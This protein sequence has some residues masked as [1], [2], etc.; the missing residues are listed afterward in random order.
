MQGI[1]CVSLLIV[2]MPSAYAASLPGANGKRLFDANC[3]GCHDTSVLTRKDR[4]I[5]SLDA[6]REQLASCAHTAK[7]EF[8]ESEIQDLL[9]Y[10]NDQFY[11]FQ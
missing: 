8:A 7:K 2:L 4:V 10:L 11:H 1:L 3:T 9:R 6:L 5:Q